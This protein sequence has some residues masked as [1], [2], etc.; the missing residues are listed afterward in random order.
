MG[1]Y[2]GGEQGKLWGG[3]VSQCSL[4]ILALSGNLGGI[5]IPY[6]LNHRISVFSLFTCHFLSSII[7]NMQQNYNNY[8]HAFLYEMQYSWA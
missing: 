5:F 6:I 1:I 4:V 8:I 7:R 2:G 3:G